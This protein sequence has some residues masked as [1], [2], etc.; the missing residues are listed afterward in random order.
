MEMGQHRCLNEISRPLETVSE[1]F[2]SFDL[3][4]GS[5]SLEWNILYCTK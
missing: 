5:N 2:P 1:A 3:Y 4:R